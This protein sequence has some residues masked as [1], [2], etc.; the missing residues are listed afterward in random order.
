MSII[1]IITSN[2]ISSKISFIS[3]LFKHLVFICPF[4]LIDL[5]EF[6]INI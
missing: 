3:V 2:A 4:P 5:P 6:Q 1:F